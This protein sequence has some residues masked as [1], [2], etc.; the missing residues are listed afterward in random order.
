MAVESFLVVLK[1]NIS[2]QDTDKTISE[3]RNLGGAVDIVS[4][5]GRLMVA[6][7]DNCF[8]NRLRQ[9]ACVKLVGGVTVRK[10]RP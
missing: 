2:P 7:F 4:G 5:R 3:I 9:L 6:R 8:A 1:D 10:N